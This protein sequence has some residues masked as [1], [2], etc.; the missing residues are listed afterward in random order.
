MGLLNIAWK[1]RRYPAYGEIEVILLS[2]QNKK[3]KW[4]VL[5]LNTAHSIVSMRREGLAETGTRGYYT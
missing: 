1:R 3:T 4:V 2:E 5:I